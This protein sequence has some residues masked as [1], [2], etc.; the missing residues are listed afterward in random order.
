VLADAG[1]APGPTQPPSLSA[2]LVVSLS[3]TTQANVFL[4]NPPPPPTTFAPGLAMLADGFIGWAD[5]LPGSVTVVDSCVGPQ[6][7]A[8]FGFDDATTRFW[9]IPTTPGTMCTVTMQATNLQ[10]ATRSVSAPYRIG[11]P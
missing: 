11:A 1:S 7:I 5:G 2:V 3:P 4:N 10:G 6:P 8:F 9:T